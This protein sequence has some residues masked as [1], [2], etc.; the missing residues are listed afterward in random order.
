MGD[1][2]KKKKCSVGHAVQNAYLQDD[3]WRHVNLDLRIGEVRE[4]ASKLEAG[5]EAIL[6]GDEVGRRQE[7][8]R[9]RNERLAV[10]RRNQIRSYLQ[11]ESR[12]KKLDTKTTAY[13]KDLSDAYAH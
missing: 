3:R 12:S 7:I 11:T 13:C 6:A 4:D 8:L 1:N 9:R 2:E 5:V 10:T